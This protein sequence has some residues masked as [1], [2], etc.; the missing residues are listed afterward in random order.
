MRQPLSVLYV[1]FFFI[2]F[3]DLL[4]NINPYYSDPRKALSRPGISISR[5]AR[6]LAYISVMAFNGAPHVAMEL[7]R[8][9]LASISVQTGTKRSEV[10][11]PTKE[12][13]TAMSIRKS[14]LTDPH[15]LHAFGK[16][17]L[18]LRNSWYI[19]VHGCIPLYPPSQPSYTLSIGYP[20]YSFDDSSVN[21]WNNQISSFYCYPS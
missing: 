3:H 20:G 15:T 19:R 11:A 1:L 21:L 10:L 7:N 6:I 8:I 18:V 14:I 5:N 17:V 12:K 16:F 9:T 2:Y 4:F 13:D